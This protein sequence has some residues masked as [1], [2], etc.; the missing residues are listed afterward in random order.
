MAD[1]LDREG[2]AVGVASGPLDFCQFHI[3]ALQTFNDCR[4]IEFIIHEIDLL[5]LHA[6]CFQ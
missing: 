6:V 3:F 5:I 2:L 1:L 4:F